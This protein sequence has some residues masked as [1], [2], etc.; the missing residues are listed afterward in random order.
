MKL[1]TNLQDAM[2]VINKILASLLNL[3]LTQFNNSLS[4]TNWA[5]IFLTLYQ[6][7]E[8]SMGMRLWF[9]HHLIYLHQEVMSSP[10]C[11]SVAKISQK[12][13]NRCSCKFVEGLVIDE[14]FYKC[15]KKCLIALIILIYIM[16]IFNI[17]KQ[18]ELK[19]Q[20]MDFTVLLFIEI[21]EWS[22]TKRQG[23]IYFWIM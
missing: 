12:V 19:K 13:L 10:V 14:K 21:I 23:T 1:P 20:T 7:W 5:F 17:H 6:S 3:T 11:L 2:K 15:K 8:K 16:Q 18:A 9:S 4:T 22:C